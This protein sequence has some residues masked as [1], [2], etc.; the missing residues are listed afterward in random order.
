MRQARTDRSIL[1]LAENA[2]VQARSDS[3]LR[4]RPPNIWRP[5]R[6]TRAGTTA[7]CIASS[8]FYDGYHPV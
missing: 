2:E 8:D 7:H 6:A 4:V 3:N 1:P 5:Q